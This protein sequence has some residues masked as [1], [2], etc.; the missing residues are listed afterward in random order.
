MAHVSICALLNYLTIAP[1]LWIVL[2]ADLL[3]GALPL[4]KFVRADMEVD[5][6]MY[7]F[8]LLLLR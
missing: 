4:L 6:M 3:H 5:V 7:L 8:S 1:V 2:L